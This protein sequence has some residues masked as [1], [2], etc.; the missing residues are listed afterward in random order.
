MRAQPKDCANLLAE[1]FEH[2]LG[3]SSIN[4]ARS[5]VSAAR[6]DGVSVGA[7][8]IVSRIMKGVFET[9]PSRPRYSVVWDVNLVLRYL[10][11]CGD[12]DTWSLEEFMYPD[13][14]FIGTTVTVYC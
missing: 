1:L 10:C 7:G 9:R 3:Y 13:T 5:A 12:C 4:T 8:P 14:T 6:C 11:S 2:G